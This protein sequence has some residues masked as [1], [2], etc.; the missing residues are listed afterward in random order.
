MD[1]FNLNKA[2]VFLACHLCK[3]KVLCKSVFE[4]SSRKSGRYPG[5]SLLW[6]Y[7]VN[8]S[9][10]CMFSINIHSGN[11]QT[12]FS[13]WDFLF[14]LA[15]LHVRC[16]MSWQQLLKK[17]KSDVKNKDS[18]KVFQ[19]EQSGLLW[20]VPQE[21]LG[22]RWYRLLKTNI[23][24]HRKKYYSSYPFLCLTV[25]Q[26]PLWCLFKNI[27][28]WSHMSWEKDQ[29]YILWVHCDTS[30]RGCKCVCRAYVPLPVTAALTEQRVTNGRI[31]FHRW[32]S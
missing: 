1:S 18:K 25:T 11:R 10:L 32:P 21:L 7:H 3:S 9:E 29:L 26:H 31:A 6:I 5:A 22:F 23:L 13:K 30:G 8:T 15:T 24:T 14:N 17:F 12:D 20:G 16:F 27:R 4:G 28:L 2:G 19:Q